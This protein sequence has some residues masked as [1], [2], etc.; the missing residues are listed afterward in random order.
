MSE[1]QITRRHKLS[2]EKALEAAEHVAVDLENK[3]DLTRVW[4]EDG[5]LRFER[6]GVDG[7]L[8]LAG[9]EVTVQVHLGLF[10]LPFKAL[11]EQKIQQYFDKRFG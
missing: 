3:F 9:Q 7:Q 10:Y 11:L 8:T 6:P 5:I 4:G 1:I 2:P